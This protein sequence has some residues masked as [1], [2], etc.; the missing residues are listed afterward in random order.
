MLTRF[1]RVGSW[2]GVIVGSWFGVI[3]A[4]ERVHDPPIHPHTL[5]RINMNLRSRDDEGEVD[6]VG[7]QI[8]Q[9]LQ[10][11]WVGVW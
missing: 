3:Q 10:G 11:V 6:G 2:F 8:H 9:C 7:D 5:V 4:R 1:I